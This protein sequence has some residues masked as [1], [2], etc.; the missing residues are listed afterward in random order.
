[1]LRAPS[2]SLADQAV[3]LA[4]FVD[5]GAG[6]LQGSIWTSCRIALTAWL[7]SYSSDEHLHEALV[8]GGG[9][10]G[11][12]K[13]EVVVVGDVAGRVRILVAGQ[14]AVHFLQIALAA[15][16]GP[17]NRHSGS[18]TMRSSSPSGCGR[19]AGPGRPRA[20]RPSGRAWRAMPSR[21]ADP[22][23]G[24][25]AA[26]PAPGARPGATRQTARPVQLG[27][28]LAARRDL[29]GGDGVEQALVDAFGE[30]L[31]AHIAQADATSASASSS[32][33]GRLAACSRASSCGSR[34]LLIA[35]LLLSGLAACHAR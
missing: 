1:M 10:D 32:G 12:M 4:V 17:Q 20:C 13:A 33:L 31:G 2:A 24:P 30:A 7:T 19:R 5:G 15:A 9:G 3:D 28:R 16:Q 27:G 8:A 14:H 23:A 22:P 25:R 21:A 34:V 18:I 29:T 26:G 35:A 11:A 6:A